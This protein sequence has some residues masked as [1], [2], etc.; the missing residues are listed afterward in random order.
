[1][2][3]TKKKACTT[4]NEKTVKSHLE[5]VKTLR[6]YQRNILGELIDLYK[7]NK[8]HRYVLAAAPGAGKTVI[9]TS[10]IKA[11]MELFPEIRILVLPHSTSVLKENFVDEL[12]SEGLTDL[13]STDQDHDVK[14]DETKNIQ[15]LLP[16]SKNRILE[17][18]QKYGT[19]D[20]II[21]DEAHQNY[22]TDEKEEKIGQI[23]EIVQQSKPIL[24]LLMTGTPSK[25]IYQNN[26]FERTNGE[27]G[28]KFIINA[29]GMD[30]IRKE[31]DFFHKI[32]FELVQS[33]YKF[34]NSDYHE[35]SMDLIIK[36]F[37]ESKLAQ[38]KGTIKNVIY[39]IVKNILAKHNVYDL[40]TDEILTTA[41]EHFNTSRYGKSIIL[42]KTI[43][44]A[45]RVS[46]ELKL[47]GIKN[48]VSTS[49]NDQDSHIIR[50][51]KNSDLIKE[52][53]DKGI[54]R[55]EIVK[56]FNTTHAFVEKVQDWDLERVLVVVARAREG[57][58]DDYVINI[59]DLTMTHNV[60]LIYQMYCRGVRKLKNFDGEKLFVKVTPDSQNYPEFTAHVTC[61]AL[62]LTN[63]NYLKIF[64]GK[65]FKDI[66]IPKL[67]VTSGKNG[68]LK[69]TADNG[70]DR[71][72][73][74]GL[75][76]DLQDII[77]ELLKDNN[78]LIIDGQVSYKT[79]NLDEVLRI[80]KGLTIYHSPEKTFEICVEKGLTTNT[81]YQIERK[82]DTQLHSQPHTLFNLNKNG[83][84]FKKVRK[85]LKQK[86][87]YE[88]DVKTIQECIDLAKEFERTKMITLDTAKKWQTK[89]K[90]IQDFLNKKLPTSPW[91]TFTIEAKNGRTKQEEFSHLLGHNPSYSIKTIE[92]TKSLFERN[93]LKSLGEY[94]VKFKDIMG[95]ESI[96]LPARIWEQLSDFSGTKEDFNSLL[97]FAYPKSIEKIYQLC[98]EHSVINAS[99]WS[100]EYKQIMAK[101]GIKLPNDPVNYYQSECPGGYDEF[102]KRLG[103]SKEIY[104]DEEHKSIII[105]NNITSSPKYNDFINKY[106][107]NKDNSKKLRTNIWERSSMSAKEYFDQIKSELGIKKMSVEETFEYC[108]ENI[109]DGGPKY[110]KCKKIHEKKLPNA[111]WE[112]MTPKLTQDEWFIKVKEQ[113][114]MTTKTNIKR[115]TTNFGMMNQRWKN[116]SSSKLHNELT[117][118]PTEF[119]EYHKEY[120]ECRKNWNVI[121]Y[122]VIAEKI[123]KR[124]DFIVADLGCGENLLS[125]EIK[126][127]VHP[128]DHISVD[129]QVTQCDMANLPLDKQSVD[130]A[131]FSLSL[132]GTNWTDYLREA[133]RI[134]KNCGNLYIAETV[135][136]WD[137]KINELT[138]TLQEI[139]F[140][141]I[142][143][144][145]IME[146]FIFIDAIK[147]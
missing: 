46:Q 34:D 79:T 39:A 60:D 43:K 9:S 129:N 44:Q 107:E 126:N 25:F 86:S 50:E 98:I 42:C 38:T 136:S 137:G 104:T 31:G 27:S 32:A 59:V 145:K 63:T 10:F 125:K 53:L 113:I 37:D 1:M 120:S 2:I 54:D 141:L 139:G 24:E 105:E 33:D 102:N 101:E 70:K 30:I 147:Q 56:K 84:F 118:N 11:L 85:E 13:F 5:D 67:K 76:E 20:L 96:K 114:K 69:V 40:S 122:L 14:Y 138:S 36:N 17:I 7:D 108:V 142:G 88:Y 112:K 47:I 26:L 41:K 97:G 16:Q 83:D 12:K 68:S 71:E 124:P 3:V 81:L 22:L 110:S 95:K 106:N 89:H 64:N 15:V 8:G 115:Q 121:P 87:Q 123:S 103:W 6:I 135:N 100:K 127:K 74:E 65:N 77:H 23:K 21:V 29:V 61:A 132:M 45:E 111:P 78:H 55:N 117:N 130:I 58:S 146:Q 131:V 99:Q 82:N 18:I 134:L 91:R 19:F 51:F 119:Y 94:T 90:E 73:N 52:Q 49:E 62:M 109:L 35:N 92:E 72:T 66:V 4:K 116:Q 80:L 144:P 133:H 128:F 28:S 140:E 75:K 48:V 93:Q 143:E 57:Y